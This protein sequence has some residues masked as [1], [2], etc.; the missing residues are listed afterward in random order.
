MCGRI[1]VEDGRIIAMGPKVNSELLASG[2]QVL[3]PQE[4][5]SKNSQFGDFS[6][7][8]KH[9]IHS[10]SLYVTN[11]SPSSWLAVDTP[12]DLEFWVSNRTDIN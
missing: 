2:L 6:K 10:K 8:W 7:V 3:A 11:T 5:F 12:K 9:L 1:K 4:I